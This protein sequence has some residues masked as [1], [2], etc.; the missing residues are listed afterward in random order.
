MKKKVLITGISGFVGTNLAE[1]LKTD[2]QIEVY[3]VSRNPMAQ[4][5]LPAG[6]TEIFSYEEILEDPGHE[7]DG[8]VHLAGKVIHN[9]YDEE[10]EEFLQVNLHQTRQ[11]FDRFLDD[12][13]ASIFIFLSTIHV[14]TERPGQVIDEEYQPQPFTPYGRS[15]YEAENYIRSHIREGK[16]FYILRPSMIHGPGNKGNLNLL[17]DLVRR[18]VPYPLGG[19]NNCRSFVSV[20]NLCFVIREI[21][22]SSIP[23]GLYH[24]ADDEATYTHDLIRY[25]AESLGKRARIVNIP[26]SLLRLTAFMA[27]ILPFIPLNE[28]RLL[29]LTEDFIVSNKKIKEAI[30]KPLPVRAEEGLRKTLESF[31]V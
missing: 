21:L 7:F 2:S 3:G 23:A 11:I 30:G 5:H 24:I 1:Y 16:Q 26:L 27:R 14:L 13:R 12:T 6:I 22:L 19:I 10:E 28:H 9:N 15:K 31:R 29:K 17:Y 8:Y 25:I 20:E 4:N 18:G